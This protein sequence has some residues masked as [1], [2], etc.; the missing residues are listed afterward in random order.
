MIEHVK[1]EQLAETMGESDTNDN[2][3]KNDLDTSNLEQKE[4]ELQEINFDQLLGEANQ[5]EVDFEEDRDD[6]DVSDEE[7]SLGDDN[8]GDSLALSKT[9]DLQ[10][11]DSPPTEEY[12]APE[13]NTLNY[14]TE[15]AMWDMVINKHGKKEFDTCYHI[16]GKFKNNRFSETAQKQIQTEA[17]AE[18]T[19]LGMSNTTKQQELIGLVSSY[20]ILEEYKTNSR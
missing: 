14:Q 12:P 18:L 8:L 7:D 11:L 9:N 3:I 20:M 4:E 16:I 2:T 1:S 17:S 19:K 13:N 5:N 10:V 15:N 6:D